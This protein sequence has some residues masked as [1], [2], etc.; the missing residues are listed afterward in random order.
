VTALTVVTL[1]AGL[2]SPVFVPLT[3]GLLAPLGWRD[4]YLTLAGRPR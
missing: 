4:T 1:L 2:A 3:A